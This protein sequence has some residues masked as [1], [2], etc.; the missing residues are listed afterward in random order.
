MHMTIRDIAGQA[1]VIPI[2]VVEDPAAAVPLA[3]ALVEG[4]LPVIEVTLR[5]EAAVAAARAM[6]DQVPGAIIG[7]GTVTQRDHIAAALDI[8]ARFI[9]SPGFLPELAEHARRANLAYLPGIMTPSELMMAQTL[10]L[11]VL[12]FFPAEPAGGVAALKALHGPFPDIRFCPTGG[13]DAAK[14][15]AYLALPNVIAVGGSWIAPKAAIDAGDWR[16]ITDLARAA[17]ELRGK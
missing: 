2:V 9:V 5:T 16:R 4:G 17:R 10:G 14:A 15:P 1:P 7:L 11:S 3:R 12:K 13:I 6:I 8:D